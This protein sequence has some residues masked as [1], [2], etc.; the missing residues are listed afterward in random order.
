MMKAIGIPHHNLALS[1]ERDELGGCVAVLANTKVL[2]DA[3]GSA[4]R[5]LDQSTTNGQLLTVS[6]QKLHLLCIIHIPSHR[7]E[8]RDITSLSQIT[9]QLVEL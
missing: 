5:C 8:I 6:A 7:A 9:H 2:G 4:S 3:D 1:N